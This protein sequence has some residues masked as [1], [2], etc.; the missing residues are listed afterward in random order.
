MF[1]IS[2]NLILSDYFSG[3]TKHSPLFTLIVVEYFIKQQ[4]LNNIH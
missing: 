2:Y 4:I 3:Y 1:Q